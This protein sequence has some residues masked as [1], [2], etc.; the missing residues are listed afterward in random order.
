VLLMQPQ[1]RIE[2]SVTGVRNRDRDLAQRQFG[3]FL[4]D[5]QQTKADLVITPEYSMPWDTLVAAIKEGKVPEEGKIWAL[6]CESIR[7][8]DLDELKQ[9]LSSIVSIIY[10][11]LD[12]KSSRFVSPLAYVFI[13]QLANGSGVRTTVLVQFKTYPMGDSDHFEVS[14]MQRGTCIYQFGDTS[15]SLKLVSLICSDAFAF[16]DSH[17]KSVYN[18]A[19]ILHIQLNP[20]PQHERFH[21]V[22]IRLLE[23]S[24]DETEVLCLN[25]AGDVH[26]CCG[27]ERKSWKNIAGSA[28][29]VKSKEFDKSDVTLSSNHQRGL[30]YT[31]LESL[32]THAL[33]FN[34][35]PATYLLEAT[36]VAHLAVPGA[37]SRRR[38]PQLKRI[39]TWNDTDGTWIEQVAAEDGFSAVVGECGHAK[40]EIKRI[41]DRNPLEAERILALCAGKIANT[42][43]WHIVN[44]LDSCIIDATEIIRRLTFCQDTN[45]RAHDFRI[46]RLKR[47]GR[48]WDILKTDDQLQPALEDFKGG[49]YFEWS[50]SFPHQNAISTSGKR[51]T[52]IY[53]GEETSTGQVEAVAKRVADHLHTSFTNP[54]ESHNARQRLA[55]WYRCDDSAIKLYKSDRFIKYD[56]PGDVS[57]FDIGREE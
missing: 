49:F 15:Q 52:V 2:A 12:S 1:G 9:R 8:S 13:T 53:M 28:W 34:F 22:R 48:L 19:L 7:V 25:W 5:A 27:E 54:D 43:E 6:G 45:E 47:C 26:E 17:A 32:R 56:N 50:P 38:G 40:D 33:F 4:T 29:Y 10:E 39:C 44:Q 14:G 21:G 46:A 11:P 35:E 18:R 24:G 30:Y 55:V 42:G 16:E 20:N 37:V 51:A 3:Q 57:E 36:K 31:W 41:A 23:Y